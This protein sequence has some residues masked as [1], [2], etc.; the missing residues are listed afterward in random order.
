MRFVPVSFFPKEDRSQFQVNYEL[1][2]GTPLSKTKEKSAVLDKYLRSYPGVDDVLVAIGA[3]AERK[4]NVAR[5]DV[6]LI[7][8]SERSFSQEDIV[9]RLR[10]DLKTRFPIRTI[11]SKS[12]SNQE[13]WR[14]PATHT[15]GSAGQRSR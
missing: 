8:K 1:P 2:E 7:P 6:R 4:P 3:N 14:T 5:I 15:A 11:K 10:V 13:R 12:L 9:K